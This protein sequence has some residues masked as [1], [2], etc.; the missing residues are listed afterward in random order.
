MSADIDE[1]LRLL[2]ENRMPNF[3]HPTTDVA[4]IDSDFQSA[5]VNEP[6]FEQFQKLPLE[7][8]IKIIALS[9]HENTTI[10]AYYKMSNEPGGFTLGFQR[11]GQPVPAVPHKCQWTRKEFLAKDGV[12]RDHITYDI[13]QS[14]AGGIYVSDAD[15]ILISDISGM[16]SSCLRVPVDNSLCVQRISRRFCEIVEGT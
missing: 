6:V 1:Q 5:Q 7:L 13:C 9:T 4:N 10:N 8:Q 3:M 16:C 11:T 15:A 2:D 14:R 12:P